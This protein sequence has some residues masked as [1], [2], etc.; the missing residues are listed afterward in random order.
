MALTGGRRGGESLLCYRAQ[1]PLLWDPDHHPAGLAAHRW[2][3]SA[4]RQIKGGERLSALLHEMRSGVSACLG[5]LG[6]PL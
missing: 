4:K 6:L 2:V 5:S 3:A 1:S